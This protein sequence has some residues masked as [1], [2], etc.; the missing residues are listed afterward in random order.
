MT[1][2]APDPRLCNLPRHAFECFGKPH[3]GAHYATR[4]VS[5]HVLDDGA[6]CACCGRLATNAHH[7]PPGRSTVEVAGVVLR[8]SLFAVCG[9]GTTGCHDGWHGGAR[10]KAL[11]RWDEE[12]YFDDWSSGRFWEEG[13]WPHSPELYLFGFWEMYDLK[14][15]RIW[16]VREE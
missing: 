8:P 15:G 13:F 9:S 6:L 10:F 7:W 4:A 14:L 2:F 16:T 3:V 5:S 11:W 1:A 12:R